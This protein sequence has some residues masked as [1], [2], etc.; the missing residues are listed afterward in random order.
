M[1]NAIFKGDLAEVSFGKETGLR[2]DG[3][4]WTLT[5][6]TGNTSLITIGTGAY[7]HTGSS[8]VVEIPDNILVGCVLRIEGGSNFASDDYA[9][10][11][12]TYYISANDTS[13]EQLLFNLH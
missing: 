2:C 11:R 3:A 9:T 10:T 8:T 4:T 12:R 6:T 1:A 5:S 13:M 7:W